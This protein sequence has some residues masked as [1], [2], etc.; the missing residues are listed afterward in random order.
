MSRAAVAYEERFE[1]RCSTVSRIF[2]AARGG[3]LA[4]AGADSKT[5]FNGVQQRELAAAVHIAT[6]GG[7]GDFPNDVRLDIFMEVEQHIAGAD[8]DALANDD[9]AVVLQNLVTACA[10]SDEGGAPPEAPASAGDG[11]P[12]RAPAPT[13]APAPPPAVGAAL[14][15]VF[16]DD[17]TG[18]E[19]LEPQREIAAGHIWDDISRRIT[20]DP[21]HMPAHVQQKR[22]RVAPIFDALAREG[23]WFH[24][25]VT[26]DP[27]A[28]ELE[29]DSA[30]IDTLDD[31]MPTL[32]A[33]V[34]RLFGV[35]EPERPAGG[36]GRST[37]ATM[38]RF[39]T[40]DMEAQMKDGQL[41]DDTR[42]EAMDADASVKAVVAT[43]TGLPTRTGKTDRHSCPGHRARRA[44]NA[45]CRRHQQPGRPLRLL[46]RASPRIEQ[47][48]RAPHDLHWL[49]RVRRAHHDD[50][51]GEGAVKVTSPPRRQ[52]PLE[53]C[54]TGYQEFRGFRVGAACARARRARTE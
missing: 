19:V 34:G 45:G 41:A 16:K 35:A 54:R 7:T 15:N 51:A 52:D 37:A 3:A 9:H 13:P 27:A 42:L 28:Y 49:R 40:A 33:S 43:I 25:T 26:A 39:I 4:A 18:G 17:T 48:A 53:H 8:V 32:I 23:K 29:N 1:R 22:K 24:A 5:F 36:S 38:P 10:T 14:R 21:A 30:L 46:H 12:A 44:Q 47:R 50:A 31:G 11:A 2:A 20:I 6:N